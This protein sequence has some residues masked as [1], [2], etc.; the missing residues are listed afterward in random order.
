[1]Y[2][3][4]GQ[5]RNQI[6]M[7]S[8]EQMVEEESVVRIIDAFVDMPDLEQFGFNLYNPVMPTPLNNQ[9]ADILAK[10]YFDVLA[11]ENVFC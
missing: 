9:K 3:I 10:Y 6:R 11:L 7:I 5:N 8:L 1:M 2:H 4:Q